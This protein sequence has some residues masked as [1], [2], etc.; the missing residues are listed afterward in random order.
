MLVHFAAALSALRRL[1]SRSQP[2]RRKGELSVVSAAQLDAEVVA[3]RTDFERRS[4]GHE[5]AWA[6]KVMVGLSFARALRLW[7]NDPI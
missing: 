4:T 2:R 1:P 6:S 5:S 3:F 7:L